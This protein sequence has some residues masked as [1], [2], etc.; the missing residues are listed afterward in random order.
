[1]INRVEP[2][3]PRSLWS[4]DCLGDAVLVR[5]VLM[6]DGEETVGVRGKCSA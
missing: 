1:M 4:L 6:D 3:V 5:S 2:H